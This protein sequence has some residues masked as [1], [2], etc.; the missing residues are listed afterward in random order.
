MPTFVTINNYKIS[1]RRQ[2]TTEH[3]HTASGEKCGKLA[4]EAIST[5]I[6]KQKCTTT[7]RTLPSASYYRLSAPYP[8]SQRDPTL[9]IMRRILYI[10]GDIS[11]I[12]PLRGNK[13]LK[14]NFCALPILGDAP[15]GCLGGDSL[16]RYLGRVCT[17]I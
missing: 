3:G 8:R 5:I 17:I 6:H 1:C 7:L 9:I 15:W 14:L 2:A 13:I 10:V 4:R 12:M 16:F 11:K